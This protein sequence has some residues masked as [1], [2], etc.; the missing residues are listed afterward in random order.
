[1]RTMEFARSRAREYRELIGMEPAGLLDRV[2]RHLTDV[3][4]L[5][6]VP[7]SPSQLGGSSGE[8][9]TA[10]GVLKYDETLSEPEKL[11]LFAHELGHLVLHKRLSDPS[12]PIDPVLA[13]A[14][15]EVGPAAIARY[16]PRTYEEAQ[17]SA[18]ALEFVCP[19]EAIWEAWNADPQSTIASLAGRFRCS[20][21]TARV[22]LAHA[23]HSATLGTGR[24]IPRDAAIPFSDAQLAAARS[25]GR[26]SIVD[27]GPG[28]GK[29]ATSIRRVRFILE[30][31]HADPSQILALT[32]SNEAAQELA[33]R[34]ASAFGDDAADAM[35]IRTFHG[36][37]MEF[38]HSHGHHVGYSEDFRLLDEDGEAELVSLLLGRVPCDRLI[39]LRAPMETAVRAVEHINYC[40]HR[41]INPGALDEALS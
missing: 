20:T 7:M 23:L 8:I 2:V 40:K 31:Q 13:S 28:T 17:A 4:K 11:L 27:A 9:D 34:I 15:G 5:D 37:G 3:A 30:E 32:F 14:Y 6:L 22:Q 41:L 39:T 29:T 24:S 35:T 38:L 26:P 10:A 25:T 33:E 16:S 21:D 18:F 19:S 1:M 36:F 12:H